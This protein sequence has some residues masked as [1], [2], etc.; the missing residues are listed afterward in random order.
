MKKPT[1]DTEAGRQMW[2]DGKSDS[3]IADEFRISTGAVTSFRRKH[4]EPKP[5]AGG[6]TL[7][8]ATTFDGKEEEFMPK[9]DAQ[10]ASHSVEVF[11]ILEAATAELKGIQA[12]CTAGAIQSLWNWSS[13]ED[14]LN[15][16]ANIDHL[17]KKLGE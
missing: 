1:W 15:A 3:E 12:I 11:D 4:W 7:T 13:K 2:L 16:K 10:P 5:K 8:R 14:L 9:S 17:L 6:E